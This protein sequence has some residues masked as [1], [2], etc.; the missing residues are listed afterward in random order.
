M[1][2]TRPVH[3][4]RLHRLFD[5][6]SIA[7]VGASSS[8]SKLGSVML[9]AVSRSSGDTRTVFG[10]NAK[11]DD[12]SFLPSLHAATEVHGHALDLA[13]LCVPAAATPDAVRDA[14]D[15]GVGAAVIC[16]G[17]FAEAGADGVALQEQLAEISSTTGIRLLGPNTSG[18]FRPTGATVSFVPTVEHI[19]AGPVAVV[20]ASGGMNHAL[21]FLLSE[22]GVGV[23]L[24]VG[25]G[26]C[27]DVT[28]IDVL[29]VSPRRSDDHRDRVA[30]R[31]RRRRRGPAV[32]GSDRQR[33][34]ADRRHRDRA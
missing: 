11:S 17:G 28:N 22:S 29:R 25:L 19:A 10:I 26:N 32:G 33:G 6:T 3:R 27:V 2:S 23:G 8:P 9:D 12:G 21:S 16:S 34:Q 5:P 14:A 18:F 15:C 1:T 20:A 4:S 30:H 31:N 24:G 7:V 13:V